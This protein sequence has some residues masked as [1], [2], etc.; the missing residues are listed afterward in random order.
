MR[1]SFLTAF[2]LAASAADAFA[3]VKSP[4][5][6]TVRLAHPYPDPQSLESSPASKYGDPTAVGPSIAPWKDVN[7][8]PDNRPPAPAMSVAPRGGMTQG[9][10]P[11]TST[12]PAEKFEYKVPVPLKKPRLPK[13]QG[14][15]FRP[16]RV[17]ESSEGYIGGSDLGV[18]LLRGEAGVGHM[19]PFC[20]TLQEGVMDYLG[21]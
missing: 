10:K 20:T 11:V 18:T 13:N 19:E 2:V 7:A 14:G 8:W 15:H 3:P 21:H 5:R 17:M 6:S 16:A 1:F 9:V 4:N 12:V